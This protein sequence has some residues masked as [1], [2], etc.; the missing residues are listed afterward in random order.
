M[1]KRHLEARTQ[2]SCRRCHLAQAR[3]LPARLNIGGRPVFEPPI[4]DYSAWIGEENEKKR[5]AVMKETGEDRPKTSQFMDNSI[6][7]DLLGVY[8]GGSRITSTKLLNLR[9]PE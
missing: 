9:I 7:L 3:Q 2:C 6:E 1:A 8:G 4:L 5:E